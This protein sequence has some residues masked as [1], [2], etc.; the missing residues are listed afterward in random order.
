MSASDILV[1]IRTNANLHRALTDHVPEVS[2]SRLAR[3]N[4]WWQALDFTNMDRAK[5]AN[6]VA[7]FVNRV[8]LRRERS[9]EVSAAALT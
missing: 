6:V 2:G 7:T 8:F 5:A 4:G 3:R 9:R 1:R